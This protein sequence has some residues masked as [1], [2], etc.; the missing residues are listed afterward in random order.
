MDVEL[1]VETDAETD[2]ESWPAM[3]L[4]RSFDQ[5][6]MDIKPQLYM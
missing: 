4:H 6:S 1:D 3:H 2:A 5:L